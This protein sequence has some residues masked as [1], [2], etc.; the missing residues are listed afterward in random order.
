MKSSGHLSLLGPLILRA[1]GLPADDITLVSAPPVVV[2]T[3][4]QSGTNDVLS[5]AY[6]M[7]SL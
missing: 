7:R 3:I 4:P 2:K 1:A 5:A 6:P